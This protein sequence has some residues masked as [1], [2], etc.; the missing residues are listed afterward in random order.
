MSSDWCTLCFT[1]FRSQESF[2]T[3]FCS[4]C[5][6]R[7]FVRDFIDKKIKET[8]EEHHKNERYINK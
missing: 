6:Q 2:D 1:P 7:K 5:R 3:G 8:M 4:K